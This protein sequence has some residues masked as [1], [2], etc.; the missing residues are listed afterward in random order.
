MAAEQPEAVLLAFGRRVAE[1]RAA[2]GMTQQALATE[3]EVSLQYV[4]RI[5][6]GRENL[7]IRSLHRV[8]DALKAKV[9][10]L[11]VSPQSTA[12]RVGRPPSRKRSN[13]TSDLPPRDATPPPKTDPPPA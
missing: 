5:E 10:D 12:A 2:R 11:F 6:A 9:P 13:P 7:T 3:L 1:L 4:Q 8:S